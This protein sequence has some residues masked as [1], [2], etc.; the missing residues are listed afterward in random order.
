TLWGAGSEYFMQLPAALAEPIRKRLAMFILRSRVKTEIVGDTSVRIGV[1]GTAAPQ[2]I[3]RAC[4]IALDEPFAIARRD[5]TLVMC[6]PG[7]TARYEIIS[8][9]DAA[10]G[11][12]QTFAEE[13]TA[14]GSTCW[15]WLDI[16]GGIPTVLAQTQDEFVP[17]MANLDAVGGVSFSKGCYPGQEI[18]ARMHYL[19]RLKRRTCIAH[20]VSDRAP[21]PGEP[22]FDSNNPAQA[23]GMIACS[24]AAP[25]GGHDV[26]TVAQIAAIEAD[27]MHWNAPDGPALE[28]LPLP[29][30]LPAAVAASAH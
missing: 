2:I 18:V 21:Q 29:Y 25:G 7:S 6:L 5:N 10:I 12:W 17:Q 15:E 30:E 19:G 14:A 24:A 4:H 1:A 22:V 11:L 23:C 26:L 9:P 20:I 8:T 27:A 3:E 28:L 16:R 13:A